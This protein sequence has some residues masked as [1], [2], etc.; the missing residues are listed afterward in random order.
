MAALDALLYQCP[1]SHWRTK[2]LAGKWDFQTALDYGIRHLAAKKTGEALGTGGS[3]KTE[4]NDELSA[5]RVTTAPKSEK[6]WPCN[7]CMSKHPNGSC[8]AKDK[9][10]GACGRKGH[11]AKSTKCTN[12]ADQPNSQ[13]GKGG[14]KGQAGRRTAT[15]PNQDSANPPPGSG[16]SS[17]SKTVFRRDS[18]GANWVRKKRTETVAYTEEDYPSD[19]D[20]QGEFK[21]DM[22]RLSEAVNRIGQKDAPTYVKFIPS[23]DASYRTR[24]PCITDTGVRK[25]LLSE[26][27]YCRIKSHNP[28]IKLTH[29]KIKFRPY[30]TDAMVPLLGSMEV[31]LYNNRGKAHK[32][33]VYITEGQAETLLGKEDTIALGIIKIDHD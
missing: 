24:V 17:S 8:L 5:N 21:F 3:S 4:T 13:K 1:D 14:Q 11:Y 27:H 19:E 32:T 9:T 2:I 28:D 20:S 30:S 12:N 31:R 29:T 23:A 33:R 6:S 26:K 16:T 18:S 22:G 25:T 7:N 15:K 10:C